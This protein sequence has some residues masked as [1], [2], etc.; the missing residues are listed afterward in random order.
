MVKKL[1]KEDKLFFSMVSEAAFTNPFSPK[2]AQLDKK[3]SG[4]AKNIQ[5]KTIIPQTLQKVRHRI[6][7]LDKQGTVKLSDFDKPDA[8]LLVFVFL[9]DIFHQFNERFDRV[10]AEQFIAGDKPVQIQFATDAFTLMAQRGFDQSQRKRFFALFYQIRRA[11]HFIDQGLIGQS[12]SMQRLRENLW[13]NIF[14][15]DIRLYEKYLWDRME[16]FSTLLLGPTGSGKGA[17]AAAIGQSGFIRFNEKKQAFAESFAS[18]FIPINLSQF[19]QSLIESELFGH[20]KGA[21]TGAVESRTGVFGLC[22]PHGAIFLDE[23]GDIDPLVQIKLLRILQERVFNPVGSGK[24]IRFNG[25]VIAA[26]NKSLRLLRGDG[27]FRDD[28]Y[29]RLC[30]DCVEVP[31]LQQRIMENPNE[32]AELVSITVERITGSRSTE[33]NEIVLSVIAESLPKNYSWP[34][35]VR[36]LAQCV[37]RVIIKRSYQ[38][39]TAAP[40]D[41]KE[42]LM[43]GFEAGTFTIAELVG[44]YCVYLY[45]QCKNYEHVAHKTGIDRRTVKKYVDSFHYETGK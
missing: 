39:D 5:W 22:K 35:N 3:I 23:I 38:G 19:P 1:K 20:A 18:M 43:A 6:G 26:T 42:R 7:S 33:L 21:F 29:Y 10:I 31:T 28:F 34:G 45:G 17:A 37:R 13:N 2:R 9:F 12:E 8:D 30:S 16:D 4:G 24:Q 11:F 32:L 25:R 41:L 36:E 27:R 15:H 44:Y 14:T 40:I